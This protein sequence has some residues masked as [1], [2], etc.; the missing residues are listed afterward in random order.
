MSKINI[1]PFGKYKLLQQIARGGMAEIFLAAGGSVETAQKFVVIKRIL[2]T[3]IDNKAFNKMFKIEGRIVSNLNHANVASIHEFGLADKQ[4]FICMEY[5]QG[6]NLRQ[7]VKKLKKTQLDPGLCVYVIS[8][9]CLGLDYAHNCTDNATGRPF[10]IIHRDISPQNIMLD[11]NG[12]VKVIDFGI[13]KIDDSEATKQGLLK[14]KFEYMS[15]EQ[16]KG[17]PLDRR[18]DVFSLGNVLWELLAGKKL[19]TGSDAF[20]IMSKIKD[21]NV[22]DLRKIRSDLPDKLVDIVQKALKYNRNLRYN[23][24]NEMGKDLS[25]LLN[26]QYPNYTQ[27][28]FNHFM[29]QLYKE[30]IQEERKRFMAFSKALSRQTNGSWLKKQYED[31]PLENTFKSKPE[32]SPG[33]PGEYTSTLTD[34]TAGGSLLETSSEDTQINGAAKSNGMVNIT[35]FEF[36][37]PIEESND[38]KTSFIHTDVYKKPNFTKNT[39]YKSFNIYDGK[40]IQQRKKSSPVKYLAGAVFVLVGL[41]LSV[42]YFKDNFQHI[43]TWI[44]QPQDLFDKVI[45][46]KKPSEPGESVVPEGKTEKDKRRTITSLRFFVSSKPSGAYVYI[47]NKSISGITPHTFD[48]PKGQKSF[49][50][51]LRKSGFLDKIQKVNIN[52][53]KHL[54]FNLQKD[55]KKVKLPDPI[56]IKE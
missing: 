43:V 36:D 17:E 52:S 48:I 34:Q 54:T 7:L 12:N 56:I 25:V 21:C 42:Y 29:K 9:A 45:P 24:M 55:P 23:D 15:P 3:H 39:E 27:S 53:Q 19:F 16:V 20:A 41:S 30:E 6:R 49:Y 51:T 50:I 37:D 47:N 22:P 4:F 10:N 5:I 28:Y 14:G 44:Q 2:S 46:P 31:S 38:R 32:N 13:A 8:R 18:T 26:K 11:F 33:R 1:K 40:K 35:S